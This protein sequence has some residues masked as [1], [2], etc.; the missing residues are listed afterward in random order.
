MS[1]LDLDVLCIGNAIVDVFSEVTDEFLAQNG[2]M[3]GAM[4]LIDAERAEFLYGR[5]GPGVER[6]GGS[7]A[8]SAAGVGA[9]GGKAGYIGKVAKDQLGDIFAHDVRSLGIEFTTAR[10]VGEAPTARSL[11]F[12]TPDAERTMQTYLGA[13]TELVPEDV[14]EALVARAKLTYLEGYLWDKPNAKAA[15]RRAADLAR[16]HGRQVALSLSDAFCVERHRDEFKRLIAE[17]VTVLIGNESEIK[18]MAQTDDLTEA[19]ALVRPM[20]DV[21]AVTRSAEATLVLT[22]D[23]THEVP[24]PP[25]AKLVDTT[26]AGDMFAAGFLW[27]HTAGLPLPTCARIGQVA[28]GEVIGHVGARPDADLKTLVAPFL[29]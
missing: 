23:V 14:P 2:L 25:V 29:P 19:L 15:V 26:G 16:A 27:A 18:S 5:M 7:V 1:A 3:K 13:C 10:L 22:G 20:A 11:I 4:T 9:L 24:V 12:I 17:T 21:V 6:S 28:A 8:N